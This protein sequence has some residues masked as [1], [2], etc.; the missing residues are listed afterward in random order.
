M[1]CF[2]EVSGITFDQKDGVNIM[3]GYLES[4]EFSRGRRA[5]AASATS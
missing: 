1:V 4:R 5:F 3:N 2:D